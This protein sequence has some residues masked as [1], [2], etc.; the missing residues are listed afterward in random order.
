MSSDVQAKNKKYIFLYNLGSEHSLLLK[1]GHFM[2][3]HKRKKF[4]RKSCK[5]YDLRPSSMPFCVCK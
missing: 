4:I 5:N 1:S 3:Y 2:L